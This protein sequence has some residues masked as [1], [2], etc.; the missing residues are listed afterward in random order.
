MANHMTSEQMALQCG[1]AKRLGFDPDKL[2][3]LD[4]RLTEWSRTEYTPSIAVKI[5]R[6]GE[7]AFEGA[8]GTAGPGRAPDSLSVDTIFPVCSITK[9]VTS[10]LLAILQEEGLV[11][12]ND[13]VRKYLPELINDKENRI[14]IWHLLTHSSGYIEAD[15]ERY[16]REYIENTAKELG[17]P[18]PEDG[19]IEAKIAVFR[20]IREKLGLPDKYPDDNLIRDTC[21]YL[22]MTAPPT[23]LPQKIMSYCGFGY[24]MAGE[25]VQ[26]VSGKNI[27]DYARENL[28]GPLKMT[29]SY[30]LFPREKLPRYIRREKKDEGCRYLNREALINTSGSGGLKTTVNDITRFGQMY[31]NR[32][33]LD[34]VRVLSC[35]SVRELTS[36]HNY[37][38]PIAEY[39]GEA[40]DSTWGLG[41]NVLKD[42]KDDT[43]LL[44]SHRSFEHGGYGGTRLLCDPDADITAA[45]FTVN[46]SERYWHLSNFNN[47][48]IAAIA[49]LK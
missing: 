19:D 13:P 29:D 17:L 48:V 5:L 41:W 8:Y 16:C 18:V 10:T 1:K 2:M 23:H 46:Y 6:H 12:F 42:K 32:G 43:G 33:S 14:R 27:D 22:K 25:I 34:G 3:L 36:D 21:F 31:L 49:D 11:D 35:A 24:D 40:F 38:L 44:H 9:P 4:Q 45:Y 28:F 15:L 7:A 26:R 37:H 30:F 39:K 20:G 47:M